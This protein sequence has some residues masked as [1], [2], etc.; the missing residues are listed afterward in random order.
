[1]S[2]EISTD[3]VKKLSGSEPGWPLIYFG[4]EIYSGWVLACSKYKFK[5]FDNKYVC[6]RRF[7]VAERHEMS[8]AILL[9]TILLNEIFEKQYLRKQF[10][11][12][13]Q[14]TWHLSMEKT[15][16]KTHCH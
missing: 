16:N 13:Q 1:V 7:P 5:F 14:D 11:G 9:L 8:C 4:S 15:E 10:C 3:L 6:P 2:T 12:K